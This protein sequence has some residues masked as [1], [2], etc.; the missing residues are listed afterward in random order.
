MNAQ[1]LF[2]GLFVIDYE[3][4]FM[5]YFVFRFFDYPELNPPS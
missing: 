1:R 4:L 5:R 2:A 3:F